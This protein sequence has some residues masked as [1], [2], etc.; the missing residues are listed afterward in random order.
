VAVSAVE[1]ALRFAAACGA[2][3]C[4][5]AGAIDPQPSEQQVLSFL[6]E[7]AAPISCP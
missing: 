3:V 6:G 1:Q 4:Q 7:S 5:G 2:L